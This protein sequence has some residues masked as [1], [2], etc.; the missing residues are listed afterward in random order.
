MDRRLAVLPAGEKVERMQRLIIRVREYHSCEDWVHVQLASSAG[1]MLGLKLGDV[2]DGITVLHEPGL[3]SPMT[4]EL[5]DAVEYNKG[6][7]KGG[8]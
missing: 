1:C 7:P 2:M 8:H 5:V 6:L 3:S 4:A